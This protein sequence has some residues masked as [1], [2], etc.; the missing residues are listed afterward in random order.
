MQ[1]KFD[2]DDIADIKEAIR[3]LTGVRN[4]IETDEKALEKIDD[5]LNPVQEIYDDLTEGG[6]DPA[7]DK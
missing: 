5:V 7:Q 2:K 6:D 3:L 1:H 4:K